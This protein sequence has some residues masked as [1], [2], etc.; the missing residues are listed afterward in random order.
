LKQ[1]NIMFIGPRIV[2]IVEEKKTSLMSLDI[3]FHFSCTQ[4][5][6]DIN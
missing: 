5:V 6:S 4:H 2:V 3:L 1:M